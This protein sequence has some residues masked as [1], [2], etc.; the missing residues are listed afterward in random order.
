[1]PN[2]LTISQLEKE[3]TAGLNYSGVIEIPYSE[4]R[5]LVLNNDDQLR[6]DI[7]EGKVFVVKMVLNLQH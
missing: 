1:M 2:P 6:R 5:E 3:S 4:F 7:F